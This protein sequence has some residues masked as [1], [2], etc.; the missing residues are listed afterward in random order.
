MVTATTDLT[1]KEIRYKSGWGPDK[2][3]CCGS[4]EY[5]YNLHFVDRDNT[6]CTESNN[7]RIMKKTVDRNFGTEIFFMTS[8]GPSGG[9]CCCSGGTAGRGGQSFKMSPRWSSLE[10]DSDTLR[11]CIG[12]SNGCCY[13]GQEGGGCS[14][15]FYICVGGGTGAITGNHPITGSTNSGQPGVFCGIFYA[16]CGA[17]GVCNWHFQPCCNYGALSAGGS[18]QH[19]CCT[20]PDTGVA[21]CRTCNKS[22]DELPF[23]AC[24]AGYDCC[25]CAMVVGGNFESGSCIDRNAGG[26][27]G[28]VN[29]TSSSIYKSQL[30]R[31]GTVSAHSHTICEMSMGGWNHSY[32]QACLYGFSNERTNYWGAG[33]SQA[34]AFVCGGPCCCGSPASGGVVRII[35]DDGNPE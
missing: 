17:C 24:D 12:M 10:S 14:R 22:K 34:S 25:R 28:K 21:S 9:A 6:P 20:I 29:F 7:R 32:N 26:I 18:F 30:M 13:A 4:I 33:F 27:C 5:G 15:P 31:S 2:A 23:A 1:Y 3:G 8:S 19:P 11:L 16:S 35:Y